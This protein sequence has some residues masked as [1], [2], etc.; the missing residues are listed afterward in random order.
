MRNSSSGFYQPS[1]KYTRL[2]EN[3]K[4]NEEYQYRRNTEE[5]ER[6]SYNP[7]NLPEPSEIQ[8]RLKMAARYSQEQ[9]SSTDN[10]AKRS[11]TPN[12]A[13]QSYEPLGQNRVAYKP[14]YE[15]IAP[16]HNDIKE[17]MSQGGGG[18]GYR[19]NLPEKT[20][21]ANPSASMPTSSHK[22]HSY[23]QQRPGSS[24]GRDPLYQTQNNLQ[25][26][27]YDHLMS[28]SDGFTSKYG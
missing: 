1:S 25:S 17:S 5:G 7:A 18:F 28:N 20:D 21:F 27:K 12:A 10:N 16:Q 26:M 23:M 9:R 3:E 19:P 15:R 14:T 4:G 11:V 2:N 24:N 8:N 13:P 6:N 22:D